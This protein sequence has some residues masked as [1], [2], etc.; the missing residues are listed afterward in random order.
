MLPSKEPPIVGRFEGWWKHPIEF[1]CASFL[2]LFAFVCF[3]I[4][5]VLGC[6]KRR[7]QQPMELLLFQSANQWTSNDNW[8]HFIWKSKT[9]YNWSL[10]P[11]KNMHSWCREHGC[12][13]EHMR[14]GIVA[15]CLLRGCRPEIN[16]NGSERQSQPWPD[17]LPTPHFGVVTDVRSCIGPNQVLCLSSSALGLEHRRNQAPA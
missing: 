14:I 10:V 17:L 16:D 1:K 5:A 15:P 6:K 12:L 7:K 4:L 11:F 13:L 8:S 9:P 2:F 3:T